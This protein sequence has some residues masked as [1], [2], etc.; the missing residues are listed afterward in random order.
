LNAIDKNGTIGKMR[1]DSSKAPQSIKFIAVTP[2][3][4]VPGSK[5]IALCQC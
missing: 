5:D 2:V 3:E 4:I 1:K